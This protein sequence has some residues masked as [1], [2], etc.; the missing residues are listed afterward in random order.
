MH[1]VR[2]IFAQ[3]LL[4]NSV[5]NTFGYDGLH[6]ASRDEPGLECVCISRVD[7]LRRGIQRQRNGFAVH[8]I[9]RIHADW[10]RRS[11]DVL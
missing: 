8:I 10:V 3:R 7:H 1:H 6:A 9:W 4:K 11:S 5:H 2:T